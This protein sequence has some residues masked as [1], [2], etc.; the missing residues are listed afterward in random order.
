MRGFT[1]L[2]VLVYIG[3]IAVMFSGMLA[4]L[5]SISSSINRNAARA[6]LAE[7]GDFIIQK[8]AYEISLSH[9]AYIT[10]SNS[11]LTLYPVSGITTTIE[12]LAGS[13]VISRGN[14][15][16]V[17]F[18]SGSV[19]VSDLQFAAPVKQVVGGVISFSFTLTARSPD[20]E[21]VSEDFYGESFLFP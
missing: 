16:F 14:D 10:N 15:A 21:P 13:A 4:D 2:E 11:A 12:E 19:T 3:L 7:E 20:A 18:S 8:V 5:F 6:Y 1:L 17:P 9:V